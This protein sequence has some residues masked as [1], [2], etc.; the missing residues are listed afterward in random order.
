MGTPPADS[1]STVG[2]SVRARRTA[3]K[4]LGDQS[5]RRGC[6]GEA[7][8]AREGLAPVRG[9][10]GR[11]PDRPPRRAAGPSPVGR[12]GPA[13]FFPRYFR[14]KSTLPAEVRPEEH[15][16]WLDE[17]GELTREYRERRAQ[18]ISQRASRRKWDLRVELW[19]EL[20][21]KET[22]RWYESRA[23]GQRE[24]IERVKDCGAENLRLMCPACG[25]VHERPCGCRVGILC[26]TCR[27]RIA[28]IKR[29]LFGRARAD[30]LVE[31]TRRGLLNP[32]RRK[33]PFSEKFLTLTAPHVRGDSIAQRIDRVFDA[34]PL[35]LRQLNDYFREHTIKSAEWFRNFEWTSGDDDRGHPHIH[36]WLFCPFLPIEQLRAWWS[37]ALRDVGCP[38][39]AEQNAIIHIEQIRD[40]DGGARELI[41]YLTKD[42]TAGGERV[43][44]ALYA[45][46]YMALEGR[47]MTQASRGFMARA[48]REGRRCECGADLPLDVRR[49]RKPDGAGNDGM[50]A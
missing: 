48:V 21:V 47:R 7:R 12:W 27:G 50:S 10:G 9:R 41:K 40:E 24:R 16:S 25:M 39:P 49:V 43:S 3:S 44:P 32:L 26:L 29:A 23:R 30:V 35:F 36:T 14:H 17:V 38:L 6:R 15:V 4:A 2:P 1:V 31:A 19:S 11:A 20:R 5:S 37:G 28:Q 34:W 33:G 22:L 42:I 45:E 46:V 8:A 18:A 13:L